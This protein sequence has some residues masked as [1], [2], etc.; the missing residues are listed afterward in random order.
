MRGRGRLRDKA[1][2]ARS[3]NVDRSASTQPRGGRA[4]TPALRSLIWARSLRDFGDGFVAV[5]L[6]VYLTALGFSPLQIGMLAGVALFGSA[7]M[8]IAIGVLGVR[9][10]HRALLICSAGLMTA[11][12]IALSIADSY[13]VLLGVAFVGSVNPSAS[14]AS[15]FAPVEHA[16]LTRETPD[17][18]RTHVFARYSLMGGLASAGGALISATPEFLGH[19]GCSELPALRAMFAFYA[20]LGLAGA[21]LYAR[22]PSSPLAQR[23]ARPAALGPSRKI[24]CKLAALFSLDAFAGG[25][26]AQSL[27]A[28]WLFQRFHLSLSM[29]GVFFFWSGVLS[30]ASYPAA[31]RLSMRF[32]LVNTMVFTHIPASLCLIAAAFAP[33]L[34]VALGLLL[35]RA[36]LSQMDVPA[37]SSYVMAVVTEPERTA[38]ASFTSVPRS[39]SASLSP[40]LAG[41]LFSLPWASPLVIC[42]ALKIAYDVL[43]LQQF[44]DVKPPE[45]R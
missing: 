33:W 4:M 44:R 35:V 5:L 29:A 22:M 20:L 23:D 40:A 19:I 38:A 18:A 3:I 16:L 45:E 14:T 37:R 41:A 26:L 27:F 21:L 1:D 30:A 7:L 13:I 31:A 43:L 25:F 34:S 11:T 9:H 8:T 12:G 36:M 15:F 32:G 28:L 6:P 42:G 39:L 10:D 17:A 24:V 2:E